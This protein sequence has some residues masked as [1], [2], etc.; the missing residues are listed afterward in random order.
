[1]DG[2]E[3]V[4]ILAARLR[5]TNVL[6]RSEALKKLFDF[7]VEHSAKAT[8]PKEIEVA[9]AIFGAAANFDVS[10]D[11]SVRVYIHRLRQKLDEYYDGP[12]RGETSRLSIPKGTG[13][14]LAVE[15]RTAQAEPMLIPPLLDSD[16]RFRF[17]PALIAIA[18]VVLFALLNIGAWAVFWPKPAADDFA[19]IRARAPWTALLQDARPITLVVGDYYIFGE[20][21][22]DGA[23]N[24]LVRE[25]T[26]NSP[27]D[28]DT[29]LMAHPELQSRYMDL[30]L[31]YLPVSTAAALRSLMPILTPTAKERD[32]IHIVQASDLTPDMIKHTDI[33]YV[34]YLSGLGILRDPVFA[35]S[36]FSF[37]D[38][39]DELV[40][41]VNDHHYFS[42]EGGPNPLDKRLKDYGYFS[43]FTGPEGN[44]IVIIAGTRDIA[45]MQTAEAVSDPNAIAAV[46]KKTNTASSFEAFYEVDGMRR[47]NL[48]GNLLLA[49]PLKTDQ[50]WNSQPSTKHFPDG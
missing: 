22:K 46:A 4:E 50:I 2:E 7:L 49:S 3:K 1:M 48:G 8:A 16:A 34:G 12:G 24:R 32:R 18:L 40:D 21:S 9:A 11:A 17:R 30:G 37:G 19:A 38:T 33:V 36:R 43:A 26:I 15:P 25:Y 10:Q 5:A 23:T 42:Q 27:G 47:I 13:Y 35:G 39:Y 41:D 45:V 29:Y 31:Y 28:L 44:H 6:G 14:R 20:I